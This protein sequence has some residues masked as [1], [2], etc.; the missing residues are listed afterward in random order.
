MEKKTIDDIINLIKENNTLNNDLKQNIGKCLIEYFSENQNLD[1]NNFYE[2]FS[3]LKITKTSILNKV[4]TYKY[5]PIKKEL[6]I[7]DEYLL[8]DNVNADNIYM[9]ITLDLI[10]S[11]DYQIGFG[12]EKLQALNK[13]L[14]ETIAS[15]L[16][17]EE[18]KENFISDEYIYTQLIGRIIGVDI[19]MQAYQ[20][21]DEKLIIETLNNYKLN[22]INELAEYN[23]SRNNTSIDKSFLAKIQAKIYRYCEDNNLNKEDIKNNMVF[24]SKIFVNSDKYEELNNLSKVI[25]TSGIPFVEASVKIM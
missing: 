24:N 21:I 15:K 2:N 12:V 8:S 10:H 11:N 1:L 3:K 23:L 16:V 17:G 7:N 25:Q 22:D 14:R 5:N 6:Q 13:G 20:N 19:L 18:H 9:Q 4:E